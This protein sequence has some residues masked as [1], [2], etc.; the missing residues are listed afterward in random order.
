MQLRGPIPRANPPT[1]TAGP[2]RSYVLADNAEYLRRE[3]LRDK[4]QSCLCWKDLQF[5]TVSTLGRLHNLRLMTSLLVGVDHVAK[6]GKALS[7]PI[8]AVSP[9]PSKRRKLSTSHQSSSASGADDL[10]IYSWNI[11]GIQP[12]IQ[13]SITAFF[14]P[15]DGST[16]PHL[17]LRDVLRR[18]DWPSMLFL[19]E[20]KIVPG[21]AATIRSLEKSVR[22]GDKP[23]EPDYIVRLCLPSDKYNARGFERKVYGVCSLIRTDYYESR[24]AR[25]RP[26]SWDEEGRFLVTE[27]KV[28]T[29]MPKLALINVYAVNGTDH[30]YRDSVTG[31]VTGTRHDRKLQ[32]HQLLANEVRALEADGFGVVLVGDLNV[33][34]SELDGHPRLRT[35]PHQHCLNREDFIRRFLLRKTDPESWDSADGPGTQEQCRLGMIDTFR[36]LHPETRAFTYHPRGKQFGESCD[37]VDLI[38][39]S[40]SLKQRLLQAEILETAAD[41]GPSDHVPLMVTFSSSSGIRDQVTDLQSNHLEKA[42]FTSSSSSLSGNP[43]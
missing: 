9:P 16:K 35:V 39:A 6:T 23:N 41:R 26:V 38:L 40:S 31:E 12:F 17:S 1:R 25:V 33:A 42:A 32:V 34:I 10:T 20:V 24:V 2:S 28:T 3:P 29:N 11:N 21:D 4:S 37:R 14:T 7:T 5:A 19:Q 30:P 27:T 18:H 22:A 36:H 15:R 43:E 13:T 8:M